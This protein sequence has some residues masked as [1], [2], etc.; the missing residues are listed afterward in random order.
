MGVRFFCHREMRREACLK[1][2]AAQHFLTK[3]VDRL[4]THPARTGEH[5][6]EQPARAVL[7]FLI[8]LAAL[9][10]RKLTRELSLLARRPARKTLCQTDRHFRRRRACKGQT[11]DAFGPHLI[12]Q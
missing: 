7:R 12:Q 1:R 3:T 11:Q 2:E 10:I 9:Q 5:K 8:D 4:D 6:R